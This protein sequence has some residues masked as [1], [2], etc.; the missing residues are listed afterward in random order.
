MQRGWIVLDFTHLHVHTEYSLLDGSAKIK[1]LIKRVKALGMKRIAITDHGVMFGVVDFYKEA[2]ANDIKPIIGCEVYVSSGSRF[3]KE[4]SAKNFYYHLVLL[5]ENNVGYRNLIKMVSRG[6]TEG[7]YYKPRIDVELLKECRE[8]IIGLSACL[9]GPVARNILNV[10]YEEA[11]N[12]ALMYNEILGRGNFYLELQ[13][14][15][16]RDQQ[17][18]NQELL[19]MS[20]ETGIPLVCTNDSHYIYQEDAKA[21]DLLL[22]V[23]TQKT[24]LDADRMKYEG[25]QFYVKS[26]EEMKNLFS[27]APQALEN[28]NII[29]DRCN[30]QF[31]FNQYKLPRYPLPTEKDPYEYLRQICYEGLNELYKDVDDTLRDRLEYELSV[32]KLMGFI[33]YFLITWDFVKYARDNDI[34]VGPGRGSAAGSIVAYCLHITNIDPMKYDLIF[35]RFLNPERISMP[36]IDIDFC[37][38]RRQE[39]IDYVVSKYGS[40]KVTQIITFGTMAA[41]GVIRDV[42]RALA[43]PYS[44]I[45]KVAKMIPFSALGM[46]IE[47]AFTLNPEMKS[48]YDS[49]EDIKYLIDMSKKL[50]GLP[51]HSSTHAAGVVICNEP[52]LEHVPL[53]V[54]DG[55]ITTQ[56]S[57]NT[58]EEL[59]LLKMDFLGLRTLTVINNAVKEIERNYGININIDEI[60][61]G[62]A[63]VFEMISQG[64][65]EGVFQLESTGMK[66]FIKELSPDS[67]EDMIAGISLYRPGPM[68]FI[69]KYIAGKK[70]ADN[71]KYIHPSLEPIL[72]KTYGCIVYQEQ[73]MQIVRDLA[74]Y[75]LGRSDLVRRA[76]SKKKASVMAEERHNFVYGL[77]DDVPGCINNGIEKEI[78]EKI[79]DEMT[80]FAKYAFNKSHAAAYAVI[81]YQTAWLKKHYPIEFMAALLTSVMD[82]STKIAEYIHECKKMDIAV[83]QPDIN[84][85]FAHFSVSNGKIRFGLS[86]VKNV[87]KNT[88]QV[89]VK[90]R[91]KAGAFRGLSDFINRLEGR[92][93]NKRSIESLVKAGAFDSLG[94]KRA[95]YMSVYAP[96]LSGIYEVKKR[97][98]EGQ[99]DL[100][101]L[102]S[103]SS[104]SYM[105]DDLPQIEEYEAKY[106]LNME[107]EVLGVYVSGHPLAEHREKIAKLTTHTSLDLIYKEDNPLVDGTYI[108][109]GGIIAGKSVKYTKNNKAMAFIT[110]EDMIGSVEVVVFSNVYER[111]MNQLVDDVIIV[112]EGKTSVREDENAKIICNDIYFVDEVAS[113]TLWLKISKNIQ[114]SMMDLSLILG[115]SSGNTPVVIY[116][117]KNNNRS[118]VNRKYW[119][120]PTQTLID[121]LGL[122]LGRD[123]IVLK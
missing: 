60:D 16:I 118:K 110:V 92:D 66:Q 71:I 69:P 12:H 83:L 52:V 40:E 97:N 85:G 38:E 103:D 107:K 108:K 76:M 59:G 36:D 41:R 11:K 61:F 65:T 114:I 99:L 33:D 74:G 2:M 9:G 56:F 24:V 51:R 3:N 42:G 104:E 17:I 87:G 13:D 100:F 5:A 109:F 14:H 94:G 86:A 37:Y 21:H 44:E 91:H 63:E 7:Y 34:V 88:I 77:G 123:S 25:D 55:V 84:E 31:E 4:A 101:S 75:S 70:N 47:K 58:L 117:E 79:F 18:V 96:I 43:M 62:D 80:D 116:D 53:N 8:G 93:I 122:F 48:L 111:F 106:L 28:S 35:E 27:Y 39:V 26:P 49:N 46:T 98:I 30:V 105:Q 57:M 23:Q 64:K 119:V 45:D 73:V 120:T 15:G 54:N 1:E 78:A 20:G 32:V 90:E 67:L 95:Q 81:G 50:E 72:N 121:K 22:C 10:S 112:V 89:L 102:G 113:K 6:F 115:E 82:S 68:D 29:G 19:R